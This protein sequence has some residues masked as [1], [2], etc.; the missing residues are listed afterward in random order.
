MSEILIPTA[1]NRVGLRFP[2]SA[3]RILRNTAERFRGI[4]GVD[5]GLF[6]KAADSARDNVPLEVV[7]DKRSEV[8][9]MVA[10]FRRLGVPEP[11]IED[12][13]RNY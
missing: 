2:R 3:A 8:E 12:Q 6:E 10:D 11:I 7:F 5:V 13:H 9:Q 4:E 1:P